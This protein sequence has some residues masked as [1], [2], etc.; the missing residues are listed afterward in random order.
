MS[1]SRRSSVNDWFDR[2]LVS[3]LD[4]KRDDVI[5]LIMQRLHLEDLAGYVLAKEP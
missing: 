5:I 1:N 3:R 4:S 2:T